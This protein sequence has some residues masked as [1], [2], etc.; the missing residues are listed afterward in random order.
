MTL[1]QLSMHMLTL[2]PEM[3]AALANRLLESLDPAEET[4]SDNDIVWA[5][6][7]ERRYQE[8]LSGKATL[9]SAETVMREA[10]ERLQG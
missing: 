1:E 10:R 4:T 9:R 3:R 6:E 7:A 8:I 5:R 2:P